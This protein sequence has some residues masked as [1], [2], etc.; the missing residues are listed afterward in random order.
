M[1]LFGALAARL[2]PGGRAVFGDPMFESASARADLLR[3]YRDSGCAALAGE[4]ESEFFW[5]LEL[6]TRALRNA[7]FR[8]QSRRFS[9]LS[10]GVQAIREEER[11]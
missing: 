1:A 10:W 11:V 3:T 9:E 4:I 7:G 6:D 5:D 8:T 2:P